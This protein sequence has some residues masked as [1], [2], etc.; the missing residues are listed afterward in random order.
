MPQTASTPLSIPAPTDQ[1]PSRVVQAGGFHASANWSGPFFCP[2]VVLGGFGRLGAG[3]SLSIASTVYEVAQSGVMLILR[4]LAV[5]SMSR[6][7]GSEV[8][9]SSP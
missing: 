2:C 1:T 7:S 4:W 9:I 8:M 6:S 3:N 5:T